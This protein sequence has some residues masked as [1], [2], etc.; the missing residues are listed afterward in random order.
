MMYSV[1]VCA[2]VCDILNANGMNSK[3]YLIHKHLQLCFHRT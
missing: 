2:C 1:R 3:E